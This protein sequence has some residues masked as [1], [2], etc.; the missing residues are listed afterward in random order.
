[1]MPSSAARVAGC[2]ARASILPELSV[3]YRTNGQVIPISVDSGLPVGGLRLCAH[4]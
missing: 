2:S 4:R 1:M 3:Q